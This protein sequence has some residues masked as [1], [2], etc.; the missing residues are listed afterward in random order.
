MQESISK[1]EVVFSVELVEIS[2]PNMYQPMLDA[3][4]KLPK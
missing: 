1:K 3:R 4:T 2:G